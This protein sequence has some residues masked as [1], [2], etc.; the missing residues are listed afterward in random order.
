[1]RL[2]D[3]LLDVARQDRGECAATHCVEMAADKKRAEDAGFDQHG[4]SPPTLCIWRNYS[5]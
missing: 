5:I 1:L 3:D 4:S 2:I